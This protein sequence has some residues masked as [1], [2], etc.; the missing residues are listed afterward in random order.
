MVYTFCF[1]LWWA[2]P[3][4]Y[5]LFL[6][7]LYLFARQTKI[8]IPKFW[9]GAGWSRKRTDAAWASQNKFWIRAKTMW[10]S[11]NNS[12]PHTSMTHGR[13]PPVQKCRWVTAR[14]TGHPHCGHFCLDA[15]DLKLQLQDSNI[16][17]ELFTC[18]SFPKA[19][20]VAQTVES[21]GNAGD[22]GLNP[23]SERSPGEGHGNPLQYSCLE[24]HMDGGAWRARPHRV[25]E[26]D[27]TERLI[28][29]Q[30]FPWWAET[31]VTDPLCP[32]PPP[33]RPE[34]F[35]PAF[36]QQLSRRL[37][38]RNS[39]ASLSWARTKRGRPA[40]PA[41]RPPP[42]SL[43]HNATFARSYPNAPGPPL[44]TSFPN[45]WTGWNFLRL[46]KRQRGGLA[47]TPGRRRP[48]RIRTWGSQCRGQGT[49]GERGSLR[50]D[51]FSRV[52]VAHLRIRTGRSFL[53][54]CIP[55]WGHLFP[56]CWPAQAQA[57]SGAAARR[58]PG[59]PRVGWLNLSRL[60]HPE[61]SAWE[62]SR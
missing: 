1:L 5:R 34:L 28:H 45:L 6:W 53:C 44:A 56:T 15:A 58:R 62:S 8:I 12:K 30:L 13:L 11:S 23:G 27:T 51:P 49:R 22:L 20:L 17:G 10:F 43:T 19:S 32:P 29:T 31:W 39:E 48:A 55:R 37:G 41:G 26:S 38:I 4:K 50:L 9:K 57:P 24:N 46:L 52:P 14:E 33:P 21:A 61:T 59:R 3:Q 36:P 60:E 42:P 7:E 40:L 54:D 25:A 47:P 35:R 16:Q 2:L 18:S